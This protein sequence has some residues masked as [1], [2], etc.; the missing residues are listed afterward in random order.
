M[1]PGP[2]LPL[3]LQQTAFRFCRVV[4]AVEL[5][6]CFI[7]MLQSEK[8]AVTMVGRDTVNCSNLNHFLKIKT[9]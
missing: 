3:H 4:I 1:K 9:K 5:L 7:E 8:K 6:S 2:C